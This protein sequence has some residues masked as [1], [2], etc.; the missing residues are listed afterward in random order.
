MSN[1]LLSTIRCDYT[2]KDRLALNNW[3]KWMKLRKEVC[4]RIGKAI[5]TEPPC[6][7]MNRER[8]WGIDR[9]RDVIYDAQLIKEYECR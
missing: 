4:D 9:E 3:E 6:L 5:G 7:L 1:H 8:K 2:E